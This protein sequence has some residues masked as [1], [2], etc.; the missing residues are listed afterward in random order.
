[1]AT[2]LEFTI[3]ADDHELGQIMPITGETRVELTPFVP[4]DGREIPYIWVYSANY[5]EF[6]DKLRRSDLVDDL[7]QLGETK[8]GYL[9]WVNWATQPNGLL[10][11]LRDHDLM[12][13]YAEATADRWK[14]RLIAPTREV[15]RDFQEECTESDVAITVT[16]LNGHV[17]REGA[18]YGLTSK[19]REALVTAQRLDYFEA[20]SDANLEEIGEELG[21]SPQSVSGLLNR[22]IQEIIDNTIG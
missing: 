11:H 15:F 7:E 14:F 21:I 16:R 18:L 12:V 4:I 5:E 2:I 8:G 17:D 13:V 10:S 9:F 20:G 6:S 19:Q 3:D 1:M 22:G